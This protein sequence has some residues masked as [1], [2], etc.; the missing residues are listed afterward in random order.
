MLYLYLQQNQELKHFVYKLSQNVEGERIFATNSLNTHANIHSL[1]SEN[2]WT[3][4]KNYNLY[5]FRGL[6]RF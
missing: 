6:T 1:L 4:A 2:S 5:K 3:Y